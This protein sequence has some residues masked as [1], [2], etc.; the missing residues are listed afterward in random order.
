MP[1]QPLVLLLLTAIG[2]AHGQAEEPVEGIAAKQPGIEAC[3]PEPVSKLGPPS[4]FP[5]RKGL[6][7]AISAA[8]DKAQAH[9][10][11][12]LNHLHGGWE[13][14][15][16]R[17]FAVAMREDPRCLMA[18]W[19]MAMTMLSPSPETHTQRLATTSRMIELLEDGVGTEMERGYAYGLIKYIEEGPKGAAV[20]FR[21]VAGKFPR[22]LQAEIFAALFARTGYDQF[23]SANPDQAAAEMRLMEL[24]KRARY[25][26]VPIHALLMIRAE[27][28]D[29][30]P[31]IGL[32]RKLCQMEPDYAPYHLVLGHYEWRCGEHAKAAAAF[33]RAAG[34]YLA[35]MRENNAAPADCEG[36]VKAECYRVVALAS[37]G[38]FEEA[39]ASAD[40]IAATA[41]DASRPS[42]P[43]TQRLL[44]DAKT[45]PSRLL[46]RRAAPGDFAL[47]Q[48]RL[49]APQEGEPFHEKSLAHW[50]VDG[51]RLALEAQRLIEANERGKASEVINALSLHGQEMAKRQ[52]V[53]YALGEQTEW[54]ASFHALEMLAAELRGNLALAG[55]AAGHGTAFNWFR[56]AADRQKPSSALNV[57]SLLTP[58][59]MRLGD[60]H[61]A[62]NQGHQA[63]AAYTEALADFPGDVETEKRLAKARELA[64]QQPEPAAEPAE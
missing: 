60:Y 9:T 12:G 6:V 24:G 3:I 43:G 13:F 38:D 17:H 22:E 52:N 53:A 44:W 56:A 48:A 40:K 39:L 30:A 50:W 59:A 42:A 33:G 2:L 61:I 14:E 20:A 36:W 25:T 37:H 26:A 5:F 4:L 8:N 32:A 27:A 28:P 7:T 31:S 47:A 64:A 15:A 29:L 1:K 16:M 45:L 41:P 23:G 62:R 21:K 35:W 11:Q 46:L 49:P 57:P 55:P 19:G 51:I 18:H 10:L 54:R 34:L 63:V 58:M